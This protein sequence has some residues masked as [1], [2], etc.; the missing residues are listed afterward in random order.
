M[1]LAQSEGLAAKAV[2]VEE[3]PV[4]AA[5]TVPAEKLPEPSLRTIVELVFEAVAVVDAFVIEAQVRF[6]LAAIV[7]AYVSEAQ[8]EGLAANAVAVEEFP[9]RVAVTVPAE[10][11]PDPSLRTIV[12]LVFDAVAVV[13][14]FVI[15]AHVKLPLAA[16]VVAYVFDA[17]SDG[18]EA[19][20]VDVD[21]LPVSAAVIVP[22]EKLPEP[23]LKIMV[24]FEFE[25]VAVVDA[26]VI[27]AQVRLPSAAIIV[28]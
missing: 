14:A 19:R 22:A 2:A 7:V 21:A 27:D 23:S 15:E 17:Q 28:A 12:E 5:V 9:V 4:N 6:P 20:A 8:S 1:S 3:F 26:L 25:D 13:E 11:F 10:K 16:I 18:S 24:E